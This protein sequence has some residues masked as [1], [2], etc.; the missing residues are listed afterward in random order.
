MLVATDLSD[1]SVAGAVQIARQLGATLHV[2]HAVVG[3]LPLTL[4]VVKRGE[5]ATILLANTQPLEKRV[6]LNADMGRSRRP[7]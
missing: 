7:L 4:A 5:A 3:E 1:I 2:L 6:K